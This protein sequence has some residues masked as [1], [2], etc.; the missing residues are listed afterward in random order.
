MR[1]TLETPDQ[2]LE[3]LDRM[4]LDRVKSLL[5]TDHFEQKTIGLVHGWVKRKEEEKNPPAPPAPSAEEIAQEAHKIAR[6]AVRE[7]KKLRAVVV[8]T[9]RMATLALA[10]SGA[11][12][13]ISIL[14]LLV[15]AIR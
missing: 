8:K 4:G 7:S 6:L 9:H 13:L 5:A 11:G 1:A 14:G 2:M 10:L 3:R 15:A 12:I